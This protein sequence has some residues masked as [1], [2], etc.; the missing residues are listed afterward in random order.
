MPSVWL[1]RAEATI[2]SYLETPI[3]S[4][5]PSALCQRKHVKADTL[6][7]VASARIN[8][9]ERSERS[10]A[11]CVADNWGPAGMKPAETMLVSSL[12]ATRG[13]GTRIA[14]A[15]NAQ[16]QTFNTQASG[17]IDIEPRKPRTD[18]RVLALRKKH[19]IFFIGSGFLGRPTIG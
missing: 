11:I 3:V 8:R 16:H 5:P 19:R 14:H 12:E 1:D 17:S 15:A 4:S 6:K 9:T 13:F 18:F 7:N 10:V 2:G